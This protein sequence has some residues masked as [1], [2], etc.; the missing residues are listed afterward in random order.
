MSTMSVMLANME[1][2]DVLNQWQGLSAGARERLIIFGALGIVAVA[3]AAWAAFVRKP[4]R[5][6]HRHHHG[7][8]HSPEPAPETV[9][10]DSGEEPGVPRR[11]RWRRPR[12]DHRPRNP[13]LS[14]T[15][16]LPPVR[17]GDAD[18]QP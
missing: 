1:W 10:E 13:T 5:R 11:R 12:R 4:R 9:A 14:E 8:H 16:G 18:I 15:G 3:V 17:A 7:H 2:D 6:H